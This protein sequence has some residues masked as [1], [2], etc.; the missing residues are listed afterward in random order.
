MSADRPEDEEHSS[1]LLEQKSNLLHFCKHSTLV[2]NFAD[3]SEKISFSFAQ[4]VDLGIARA[5]FWIR[6]QS[7]KGE[8]KHNLF[9][10]FYYRIRQVP[11][12][13]SDPLF[14]TFL[15]PLLLH[16]FKKST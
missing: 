15:N 9:R 7:S 2:K 12:H 5:L 6:V 13:S 8:C 16:V 1:I 4:L 3:K 10:Q 14:K 11:F